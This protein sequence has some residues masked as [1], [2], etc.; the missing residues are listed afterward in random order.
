VAKAFVGG[1][2]EHVRDYV[3]ADFGDANQDADKRHVLRRSTVDSV[4]LDSV[5]LVCHSPST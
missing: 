5:G 4:H 3:L 1:E 2:T